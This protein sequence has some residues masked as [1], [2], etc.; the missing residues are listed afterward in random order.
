MVS[1]VEGSWVVISTDFV[2]FCMRFLQDLLRGL[3]L[4]GSYSRVVKTHLG[5]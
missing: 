1:V 5:L 3:G 2:T 4:M